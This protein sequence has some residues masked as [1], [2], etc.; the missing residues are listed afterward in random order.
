MWQ[1]SSNFVKVALARLQKLAVV[2]KTVRGRGPAFVDMRV[3]FSRSFSTVKWIFDAKLHNWMQKKCSR[4]DDFFP[5]G[6]T[7]WKS[8]QTCAKTHSSIRKPRSSVVISVAKLRVADTS[9]SPTRLSAAR[10]ANR[11]L[12]CLKESL[13][14]ASNN[15]PVAESSLRADFVQGFVQE[16]RDFYWPM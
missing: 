12:S 1:W 14:A 10:G 13:S 11:Q 2:N 5:R 16:W 7:F 6:I 4:S 3:I 9:W 8:V 15:A